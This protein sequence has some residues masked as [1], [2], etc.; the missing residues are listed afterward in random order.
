MAEPAPDAVKRLV[1]RFAQ[2]RDA[3]HSVSYNEAQLHR[4]FID[5]LFEALG[6][7]VENRQGSAMPYRDVIFEDSL[8]VGGATKATDY[9]FA[10]STAANVPSRRSAS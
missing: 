6:W 7:D 2:N 3:Y 8:K 4:E 9:T 10:A 1:D 5:P